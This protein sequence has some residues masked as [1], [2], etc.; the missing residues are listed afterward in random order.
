MCGLHWKVILKNVLST[1][2]T[3]RLIPFFLLF[4]QTFPWKFFSLTSC[5]EK[6]SLLFD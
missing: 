4:V 2:Y 3:E 1:D 6:M 5:G